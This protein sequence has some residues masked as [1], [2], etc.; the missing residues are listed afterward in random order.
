MI[1]GPENTDI[2]NTRVSRRKTARRKK[3][4]PFAPLASLRFVPPD[5]SLSVNIARQELDLIWRGRITRSFP[6]STSR[7][8]IGF[9]KDSFKTPTGRFRVCA[10]FG[11]GQPSGMIF[12]SRLPTGEITSGGDGDLVL[13]RILWL[14]GLDPENSN[15][16]QRYIYI[17]GTNHED[18]IGRPA[19]HGCVRM[20]NADI[21][22][23]YDLAAVGTPVEIR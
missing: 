12:R 6:I 5:I 14:D 18:Q 3:P 7:F 11:G 20:R 1:P 2:G 23:I 17:H 15:S 16:R 22:T 21:A 19:S 9:E 13:T 10:C 4:R 8:G